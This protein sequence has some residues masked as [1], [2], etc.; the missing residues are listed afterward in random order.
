MEKSIKKPLLLLSILLLAAT[1]ALS[2]TACKREGGKGYTLS[3]DTNGGSAVAAVTI[4]DGNAVSLPT[5]QR[6][7]YSFGGWYFDNE[8]FLEE[9]VGSALKYLRAD[10][11]ITLYAKW[12][13]LD[14]GKDGVYAMPLEVSLAEIVILDTAPEG[15]APTFQDNLAAAES[16]LTVIDGKPWLDVVVYGN[17]LGFFQ[18]GLKYAASFGGRTLGIYD[19]TG[20]YVNSMDMGSPDGRREFRFP[21]D[22]EAD[23]LSFAVTERAAGASSMQTVDHATYTVKIGYDYAARIALAQTP[24]GETLADGIY[25]AETHFIGSATDAIQMNENF[26]DTR[27]YLKV[28]SGSMTMYKNFY[29]YMGMVADATGTAAYFEP[30]ATFMTYSF[31]TPVTGLYTKEGA[32][33]KE[34]ALKDP[35]PVTT[36]YNAEKGLATFSWPVSDYKDSYRVTGG[37]TGFMLEAMSM[38][39]CEGILT[40]DPATL[41]KTDDVVLP[42]APAGDATQWATVIDGNSAANRTGDENESWAL[43]FIWQGGTDSDASSRRLLSWSG[44]GTPRVGEDGN[45]YMDTVYSIYG[46]DA[47]QPVYADAVKLLLTLGAGNSYGTGMRGTVPLVSTD[48][49]DKAVAVSLEGADWLNGAAFDENNEIAVTLAAGKVY[50]LPAVEI[51]IDGFTYNPRYAFNLSETEQ[52]T[53][54]YRVFGINSAGK[55]SLVSGNGSDTQK[56][57]ELTLTGSNV[58]AEYEIVICL[59]DQYGDRLKYVIKIN[60]SVPPLVWGL[61]DEDTSGVNAAD[62]SVVLRANAGDSVAVPQYT[63]TVSGAEAKVTV[64]TTLTVYTLSGTRRITGYAYGSPIEV[65]AGDCFAAITYTVHQFG[66][67][68]SADAQYRYAYILV[69]DNLEMGGIAAAESGA[70]GEKIYVHAPSVSVGGKQVAA[71]VTVATYYGMPETTPKPGMTVALQTDSACR[72]YF[73]APAPGVYCVNVKISCAKTALDGSAITANW[74]VTMSSLVKINVAA[75]AA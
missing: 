19:H 28:E 36:W 51:T 62:E 41:V 2:L 15:F 52:L 7:N 14:L 64:D 71:S 65:E 45:V 50:T 24:E 57:A 67:S 4:E 29:S 9:A 22:P 1:A 56:N 6:A 63:A 13:A 3:F 74:S 16:G 38:A 73:I 23:E 8:T 75:S 18:G 40:I 53:S 49:A 32:F 66:L 69:T 37:V 34:Y 17:D 54:E 59:T 55:R 47:A 26:N 48:G 10:S 42:A 12:E 70:A 33:D 68:S 20:A 61:A 30:L 25:T 58:Y 11:D 44:R 5:P 43:N 27:A 35:V 46:V 39:S 21:L 31:V 72:T 60:V